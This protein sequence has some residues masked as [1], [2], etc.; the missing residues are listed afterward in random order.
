MYRNGKLN[1]ADYMSRH[2]SVSNLGTQEDYTEQY[3][4]FVAKHAIPKSIIRQRVAE[5]TKGDSLAKLL[6]DAVT[7][8]EWGNRKLDKFR[9]EK[10]DFT[11]TTDGLILKKLKIYIPEKLR[12]EVVNVAHESHQTA[13]QMV[14]TSHLCLVSY[15]FLNYVSRRLNS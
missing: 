12:K 13:P 2:P 15:K 14:Q 4:N 11:I 10:K 6:K 7:N 5:E 1:P 8:N 9:S 3:I